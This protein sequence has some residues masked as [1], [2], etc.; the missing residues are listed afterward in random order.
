M[1]YFGALE[2]PCQKGKNVLRL[3]LIPRVD[4]AAGK[5]EMSV[6]AM[7]QSIPVLANIKETIG[8]D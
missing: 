1:M 7:M 4:E 5:K 8:R 6:T 3:Q 2:R